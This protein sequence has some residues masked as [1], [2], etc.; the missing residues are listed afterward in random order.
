MYTV[1]SLFPDLAGEPDTIAL[2]LLLFD[3]FF[4]CFWVTVSSHLISAQI[5]HLDQ[6]WWEENDYRCAALS[7]ISRLYSA[8]DQDIV[9]FLLSHRAPARGILPCTALCLPRRISR[10]RM[11][12]VLN[13]DRHLRLQGTLYPGTCPDMSGPRGRSREGRCWI[14]RRELCSGSQVRDTHLVV[15]LEWRRKTGIVRQCAE[16]CDACGD[17]STY[18]NLY[19]DIKLKPWMTRI[20]GTCDGILVCAYSGCDAVE[21]FKT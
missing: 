19:L 15:K 4:Y 7:F 9:R 10:T 20:C 1:V 3:S 5:T 6:S 17:W 13:P 11:I 12:T 2:T 21:K 8:C 14:R 16:R 18:L